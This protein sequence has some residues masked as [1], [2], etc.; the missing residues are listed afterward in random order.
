[1]HDSAIALA[2]QPGLPT[3]H[4]PVTYVQPAG[5]FDLFQMPFFDLLQ[6][7]QSLPFFRA[8]FDSLRFHPSSRP[9]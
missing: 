1:M 4:L 9:G 7:L 3:P 5:R 8:Q 2:A 6:N